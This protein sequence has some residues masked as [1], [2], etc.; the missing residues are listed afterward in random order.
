MI[1][2]L[3]VI[4]PVRRGGRINRKQIAS[5]GVIGI[6]HLNSVSSFAMTIQIAS[7]G[8]IGAYPFNF[9]YS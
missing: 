6:Y 3:P 2:S 1:P 4:A 5:V 8:F 7:V 9:V